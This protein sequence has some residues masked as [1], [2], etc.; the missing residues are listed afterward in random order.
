[1]LSTIDDSLYNHN[2]QHYQLQGEDAEPSPEILQLLI[3]VNI[4][5][6]KTYIQLLCPSYISTHTPQSPAKDIISL[7]SQHYKL[8]KALRQMWGKSNFQMITEDNK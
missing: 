1:M 3:P 6:C 8:P 5:H 7:Y 4:A 2:C